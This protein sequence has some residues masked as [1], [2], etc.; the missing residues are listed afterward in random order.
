MR[1]EF[2][3]HDRSAED[4]LFHEIRSA[5]ILST[6]THTELISKIIYELFK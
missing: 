5:A 1:T 4:G 2:L 6:H 3:K